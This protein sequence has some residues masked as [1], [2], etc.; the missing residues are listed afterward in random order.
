MLS[1]SAEKAQYSSIATNNVHCHERMENQYEEINI[2]GT[3]NTKQVFSVQKYY[4]E[5]RTTLR[6]ESLLLLQPK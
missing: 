3:Y 5:K 6:C 4:T 2:V 1:Y